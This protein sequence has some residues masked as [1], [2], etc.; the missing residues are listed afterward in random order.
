MRLTERKREENLNE[1]ERE[2]D[3]KQAQK[4]N[5]KSKDGFS[6]S[7]LTG[8]V[9]SLPGANQYRQISLPN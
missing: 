1:K 9:Q 5:L 6:S 2:K 7:M 8:Q 4:K 3:R